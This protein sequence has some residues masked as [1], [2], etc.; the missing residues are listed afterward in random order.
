MYVGCLLEVSPVLH[1]KPAGGTGP[2]VV[3]YSGPG[4]WQS[5]WQ[6]VMHPENR[7]NATLS[8]LSGDR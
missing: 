5:S 2:R 8:S 4:V 6:C 7:P 1:L 3:G